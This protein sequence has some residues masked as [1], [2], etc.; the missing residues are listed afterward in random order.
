MQ[1][2]DQLNEE[3][4]GRPWK[5]ETRK[6]AK[7]I[8]NWI[9]FLLFYFTCSSCFPP[10]MESTCWPT[11]RKER[12]IVFDVWEMQPIIL[13]FL[14]YLQ[15]TFYVTNFRRTSAFSAPSWKT[16]HAQL[17]AINFL[18]IKTDWAGVV[19]A[20]GKISNFWPQ[21]SRFVPRLCRDSNICATFFPSKPTQ[22][23]ILLG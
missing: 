16:Y 4:N 23:S 7:C 1:H 22:L 14:W 15:V 8:P 21:G 20:V 6:I 18:C 13:G 2:S 19:G 3:A 9:S 12:V 17:M 5:Q 10:E 11:A